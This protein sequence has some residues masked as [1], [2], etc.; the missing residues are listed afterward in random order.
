[1]LLLF[2]LIVGSGSVWATEVTDVIDNAATSSQLSSTA[3]SAWV[4][5]FTLTGTSG[6][7]YTIRS[8]GTKDGTHALQWNK[9]GY[10]Y[11]TKSG[12]TVKSITIKSTASKKVDIFAASSAYK[13]QATGTALT[14]LT[15]TT[16]GATY[17]F[18]DDYAYIAINGT[19]SS[20]QITSITIVWDDGAGSGSSDP[21]D[22]TW[23]VSPES[24]SVKA[25][26]TATA[27]ITTNYNGTLS[28][29]SSNSA[30][31]TATYEAGKLTVTGVAEGTATLTMSGEA[32]AK[33]NAISKTIDV[34]V[35]ANVAMPGTYD[36]TP[37]NTFYGTDKT[38]SGNAAA[39]PESLTG[40]Q[41][42]I[43][44][45]YS[46][47][48]QEYFYV[49][50]SQTRAYNGSTM[51][52]SVPAGFALTAIAFTADGTNWAG[53]HTATV[54]TMS[55]S[56]NWK[57]YA[58][59]VTITFGGTCR[60]ASIAVTFVATKPATITEA[61]Y[62]TWI[63]AKNVEVPA[64][65]EAY[66]ATNVKSN[67][68]EMKE[69]L[70]IPTGVPVVLKGAA[71]TY[72]FEACDVEDLEANEA[73]VADNLLKVVT[74]E[75]AAPAGSYVLYNGTEGVGFYKWTGAALAVGRVYLPATSSTRSFIGFG[76]SEATGISASLNEKGEMRKE[77]C[78]DLQGRR[79]AQPQNGLYIMG[80]KKLIVK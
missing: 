27:D 71:N 60:V 13:A 68:V 21:V 9:N 41:D 78:F 52:F 38:Y 62:A 8:M 49:N 42:D 40:E 30:V 22:A 50:A 4:N 3:T 65:V 17:T 20:T 1:M 2:V 54:G 70:A 53:E 12:G 36:I 29:V 58:E 10:L 80:G 47:G 75:E 63:P 33:F 51:T 79:V 16:D 46:K 48:S 24:I 19:A 56:K 72:T 34:T 14:S 11:A 5:A 26:K 69:L 59:E 37:N 66:I 18:E 15:A 77:K 64:G 39:N 45:V 73:D 55:D 25:G 74:D 43:T 35:T 44:I 23:N 28:V 6:A 32:T 67:T 76:D 7:E 31:A 61:G 57:G